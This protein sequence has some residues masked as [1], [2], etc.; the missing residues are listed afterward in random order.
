MKFHSSFK[1][2][3]IRFGLY[4]DSALVHIAPMADILKIYHRLA[5][6]YDYDYL[7]SFASWELVE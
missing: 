6:L 3:N 7:H 1:D 5:N 4:L 2:P